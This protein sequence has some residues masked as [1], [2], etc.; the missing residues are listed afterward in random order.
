M[1]N[2]KS[3]TTYTIINTIAGVGNRFCNIIFS[4]ALRTVFIYTLGIQYTGISSVFT[5][6]L[7]MMSLS[8]LGISTAIA[9]ALYLPLKCR[10]ERRICKLMR[11]YR[12]AYRFIAVFVT[13]VGIVIL[14]FLKLI[15][16]DVPDIKENIYTIFIL[17]VVR[18]ASSY[19]LVY[20]TTLLNAD[21]KAYIVKGIETVCTIARYI[22]E[23]IFLLLFK[24]FMIYLVIEIIMTVLQ[25]LIVTKRAES[26]YKF[27]FSKLD[28]KLDKNEL[29]MLFKDIKGLAMYQLASSVGN[30]IDN[31]LVSGFIGTGIAGLLSNYTLIKKQLSVLI[32]QF[33]TA[34]IPSIGNLAAEK[35]SHKQ[36]LIF[37]RIFFLSFFVMNFVSVSMFVLFNPFI[38]LWL[39]EDYLLTND[40]VFVVCFDF[41][42]YILLQAVAAFRNANGLF[43]KGQ[44]RP[45]V[46]TVLNVVL[47]VLLIQ[48]LGIFGTIFATIICRLLTQWYDPWILFKYVFKTG[49]C[50]FYFK[51]WIYIAIFL[52][53][54]LVTY[55]A[56]IMICFSNELMD[57]AMKCLM[58]ILIP[59]LIA[60]LF[61]YR[62]DEFSYMLK[63]VDLK[64]LKT[65]KSGG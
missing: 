8:E 32:T 29:K 2:K 5:D 17:Y 35:D 61:V 56:S 4:F 44:Y 46:M 38:S 30:S 59:N 22:L 24:N 16:T 48:K 9:T 54:S 12:N 27:A 63:L 43:V 49:F 25:N 34:V 37:N 47:S 15:I 6:I 58:C 20:K 28:E 13:L 31:I 40:V 36:Y 55:Y 39:G 10:D 3:R 41:F 53:S 1:E 50:R 52:I 23:M 19:L 11:F 14:P 18:T 21:Q 60:V 45:L 64:F 26:E 62:T 65:F 51:Y 7:T 42:L 33:F 57:F